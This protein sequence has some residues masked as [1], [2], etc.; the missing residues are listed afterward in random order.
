M[1]MVGIFSCLF[2][3]GINL[4]ASRELYIV[5]N[6]I[7]NNKATIN[8][9]VYGLFI[10]VGTIGLLVWATLASIIGI[11]TGYPPDKTWGTKGQGIF[12]I[13]TGVFIILGVVFA[14]STYQWLT[15]ELDDRGYIYC[16]ENST[17]SAMG[18]H[19]IYMKSS[20]DS[21]P[22]NSN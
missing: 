4:S 2:S 16:T 9:N 22:K 13:I 11:K 10:P 3:Y 17:L 6:E 1:L 18:K 19:E 8:L 14:L 21:D 5:I 15:T 7:M 12:T 20:C